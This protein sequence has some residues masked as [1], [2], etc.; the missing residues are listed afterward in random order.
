MLD[1]N[2]SSIDP[3]YIERDGVFEIFRNKNESSHIGTQI[4]FFSLL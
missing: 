1:L 4:P 2:E 3:P